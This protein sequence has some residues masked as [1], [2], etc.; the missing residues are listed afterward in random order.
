MEEKQILEQL[1]N[2]QFEKK[3]AL[4]ALKVV[5]DGEAFLGSEKVID[6]LIK[7]I[8]DCNWFINYY[9]EK[10]IELNKGQSE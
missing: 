8:S 5:L 1:E 9:N 6:K 4:T 7:K 10:L 3:V 2:Y